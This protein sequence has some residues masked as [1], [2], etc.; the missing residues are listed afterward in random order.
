V[1]VE[2]EVSDATPMV[3]VLTWEA[4]QGAVQIE[5]AGASWQ[6]QGRPVDGIPV[7]GL[8]PEMTHVMHPVGEPEAAVP[9]E[10]PRPP[11][12]L[13]GVTVEHLGDSTLGKGGVMMAITAPVSSYVAV[14]D[15]Q[16]RWIWWTEADPG[17]TTAAP[18]PLLDGS[19]VLFAQHERDRVDDRSVAT[20]LSWDG[21]QRTDLDTP[22][23]HHMVAELPDGR[24]TWLGH[25]VEQHQLDGVDGEVLADT[26][27][28]E[29]APEPL[30]DFFAD[31]GPPYVPCSHSAQPIDKFG[32]T[33]VF[34]WTHSNSLVHDADA[35][36]L[37]VMARHLDALLALDDVTGERVWQLGGRDA[38]RSFADPADAFDHGHTSWVTADD[39]WIFDNGV[40]AERPSRLV[41]YD[42][43]SDPVEAVWSYEEPAGRTVTFLGDVQ[44]APDGHVLGA[45]TVPGDVT[46]HDA[47]GEVV[48]R[49]RLGVGP[50]LG[51]I[52]YVELPR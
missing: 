39:A 14:L 5:G 11:E 37:F 41:H 16:G 17:L 25:A 34:E 28:V 40:H 26:V 10:V 30:F 36:L 51:R 15:A 35:G 7:F 21:R 31:E 22:T 47:E 43:R 6:V 27:L 3:P 2:L 29:G 38:T 20:M 50:V 9:F 49:A 32:W 8:V 44:P 23:G 4:E 42:L 1:Q 18:R 46:E 52:R 12:E 48:W 13:M 45:W 24:L 19:G 33:G